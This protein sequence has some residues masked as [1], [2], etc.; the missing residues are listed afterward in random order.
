[1]RVVSA[2]L[3]VIAIAVWAVA[4]VPTPSITGTWSNIESGGTRGSQTITL[5]LVEK[6][7]NL[8]GTVKEFTPQ[9]RNILKGTVSGNQFTFETTALLNG[10]AGTMIWSGEIVTEDEIW[11]LRKFQLDDG[12]IIETSSN[13]PLKLHRE[14]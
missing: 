7:G 12:R 9:P 13:N 4:G 8:T 5:A 1:M 6:D 14:K 3:S 2:V 11:V 10:R